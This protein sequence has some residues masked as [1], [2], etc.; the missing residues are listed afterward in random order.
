MP[1]DRR[2]V[3]AG[4]TT[5]APKPKGVKTMNE[6]YNE[7][8]VFQAELNRYLT[9]EEREVRRAEAIEARAD[10][11][12]KEGEEYYP[13]DPSNFAE[14]L[15]EMSVEQA[16]SITFYLANTQKE[17]FSFQM[18]NEMVCR[19]L[20]VYASDYMRKYAVSKAKKEVQNES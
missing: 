15:A 1:Q 12:L 6:T 17:G 11:L 16:G 13:L 3:I 14:V 19:M 8:R 2:A 9:K 20:W 10:E 4:A 18:N 7:D 5:A